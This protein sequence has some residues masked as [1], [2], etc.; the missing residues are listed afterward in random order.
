MSD[1]DWGALMAASL[2][3]DASAYRTLLTELDSWLRRFFT[4][5]LPM[6]MVDDVIQDTLIAIHDKRHTYDPSRPFKPW[7]GA[8]ARY[9]WIDRIR[10][11]QRWRTEEISEDLSIADHGSAVLSATILNQ[12]LTTLKPA[13][14]EVIRLVKLQGFSIEEAAVRT[15]QSSALVKVNIHRG[16]AKLMSSVQQTAV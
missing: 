10:L 12:L 3:G 1:S 7:L 9:K 11:M 8:I 4:R 6:A 13:Q 15:G 14:A 5:R 16:L 2:E